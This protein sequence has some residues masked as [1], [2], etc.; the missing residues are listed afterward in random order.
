VGLLLDGPRLPFGGGVTVPPP[1]T[2]GGFADARVRP[3]TMRL[4]ATSY[5]ARRGVLARDRAG[6]RGWPAARSRAGAAG[7][8]VAKHLPKIAIQRDE[9]SVFGRAHFE[10]CLVRCPSQPLAANRNGVMAGSTDQVGRVP[11]QVFVEL[12]P[13]AGFSA[14]TGMMRSRAA[15]A[16]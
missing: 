9:R 10:L 16:P 3:S 7:G 14:G 15:S 5:G 2:G 6:L 13:H 4:P 8:W 12:K 11:T 1:L